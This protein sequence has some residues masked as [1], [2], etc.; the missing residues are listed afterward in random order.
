VPQV[1]HDLIRR[2]QPGLDSNREQA[3]QFGQIQ[4]PQYRRVK[5]GFLLIAN[6]QE[7]KQKG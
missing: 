6:V 4:F 7:Q 2:E 3:P 5:G 1:E